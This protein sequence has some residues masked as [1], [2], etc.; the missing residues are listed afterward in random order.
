MIDENQYNMID[1]LVK[2]LA[3]RLCD[4]TGQ[5]FV[6]LWGTYDDIE[7]VGGSYTTSLDNYPAVCQL[8]VSS[9]AHLDTYFADA[10]ENPQDNSSDL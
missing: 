5:E 7:R 10:K 2:E 1:K 3:V 9:V 4:L 6:F 8:V